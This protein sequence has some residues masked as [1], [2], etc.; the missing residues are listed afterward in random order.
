[1]DL[2][3][4]ARIYE[5]F[6]TTKGPGKG[7]GLGLSTAYGIVKQSG[8]SISVQSEP[9][10]GATFRIRLP[11]VE[12]APQAHGAE[13]PS[14]DIPR[15]SETVLLVEDAEP[16]REVVRQFL[17]QGGYNVLAAGDGTAALAAARYHPGPIHIL[18]TDVVMPGLSGP[19]LAQEL[20]MAHPCMRV[21]FMSGYTDDALG[22]H[23]VLEEGIALLEK[24]FTRGS[25]LRKLRE[26]L[27]F[28][29]ARALVPA[30]PGL[31]S[32]RGELR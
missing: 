24:P 8:G 4:Q 13:K 17:Q 2:K 10:Q 14:S 22:Q 31:V 25:L 26:V 6:F 3:T 16:F 7:T 11:R 18:L 20:R 21:L 23:G 12:G 1:M 32:P 15:G 29:V 5:P 9:G 19:Q 28:D 27:D 30:V